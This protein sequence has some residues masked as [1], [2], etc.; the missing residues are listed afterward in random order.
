M[1]FELSQTRELEFG[2]NFVDVNFDRQFIDAQV[3][4]QQRRC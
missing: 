4:Y 3:D 1:N 2:A